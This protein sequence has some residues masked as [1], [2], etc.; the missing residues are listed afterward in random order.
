MYAR[1]AQKLG[2]HALIEKP[3]DSTELRQLAFGE[4]TANI[5]ILQDNAAQQNPLTEDRDEQ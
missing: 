5:S 4:D 2:A 3:F 1:W